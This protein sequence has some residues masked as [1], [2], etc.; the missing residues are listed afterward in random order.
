[1]GGHP[2][3]GHRAA[4]LWAGA[5]LLADAAVHELRVSPWSARRGRGGAARSRG[6]AFALSRAPDAAGVARSVRADAR[7]QPGGLRLAAAPSV[8]SRRRQLPDAIAVI[9]L[10]ALAVAQL[11]P[12]AG[13]ARLPESLD[14]MLQ[15]V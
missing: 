2:G 4:G 9:A 15:Y 8:R 6:A 10:A 12:A 3:A 14:L 1:M 11:W 7:R 5:R 13:P